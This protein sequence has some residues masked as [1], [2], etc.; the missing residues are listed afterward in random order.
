VEPPFNFSN[1]TEQLVS[2][3]EIA[4]IPKNSFPKLNAGM[5][6][7]VSSPSATLK[8]GNK[9]GRGQHEKSEVG[10]NNAK[11]YNAEYP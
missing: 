5:P 11:K 7:L 10:Q 3:Q 4:C 9:V 8:C 6:D 2:I 1:L